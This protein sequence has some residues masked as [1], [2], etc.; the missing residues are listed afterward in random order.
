MDRQVVWSQAATEDLEAVAEF[1]SRDSPAYAGGFVRRVREAT[2]SLREFAERGRIVP[3]FG[4]ETIR[5]LFVQSY[6]LIYKVEE[7]RVIIVALVHGR[8]DL[9]GV[10][11]KEGFSRSGDPT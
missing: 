11:G 8:R 1:I 5:E 4:D 2:R 6:R 10:W 7:F 3:E 9:K